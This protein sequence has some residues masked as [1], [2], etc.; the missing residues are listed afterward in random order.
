MTLL[1]REK[2]YN[3]LQFY[4]VIDNF[5]A[6]TGNYNNKDGGKTACHTLA[7]EMTF[8]SQPNFSHVRMPAI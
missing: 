7:S 6:R 3:V 1:A 8:K 4:R 2:I 5:V